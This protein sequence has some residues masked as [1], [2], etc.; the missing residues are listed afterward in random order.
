MS[1]KNQPRKKSARASQR[2]L[3]AKIEFM[4]GLIRRDPE[5]VDAL[6]LL[7]DHYTARGRFAEGLQ[8]DERL[9]RLEPGNPVVF[10]NLACSYSLTAQFERAAL[11]LEKALELGYNDFAWLA[12]DP[13][14]KK[15]RA[16]PLFDD[17]REKI[18]ELKK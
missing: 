14:L 3:D 5:Y 1:E 11:A 10:Y 4:E 7:G 8:V 6:Q 2:D 17:L 16:H 12:K 13:D 9:A 15:L 18:R